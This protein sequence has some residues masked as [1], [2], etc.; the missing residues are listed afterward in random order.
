M[1]I[2]AI[3]FLSTFGGSGGNVSHVAHLGGMIF[4][5]LYLRSRFLNVDVAGSLRRQWKEWRMQRA[6]RKFQVYLRKKHGRDP[7]VH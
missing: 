6:R 5:Y 2:G 3:A 4:G 7:W 1:I